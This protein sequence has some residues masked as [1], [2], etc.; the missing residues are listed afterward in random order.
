M[1]RRA[2]RDAPLTLIHAIGGQGDRKRVPAGDR[3]T[4]SGADEV[5]G[6]RGAPSRDASGPSRGDGDRARLGDRRARGATR[7]RHARRRRRPGPPQDDQVDPR[8]PPGRPLRRGTRGGHPGDPGDGTA[9]WP[10]SPGSTAR[11]RRWPPSSSRQQRRTASARHWR[12]CM[13]GGCPPEWRHRAGRVRVGRRTSSRR[14]TVT[15]STRQSSSHEGSERSRRAVWRS[16]PRRR[17][18]EDR[19]GFA[20]ARRGEPRVEGLHPVLPRIGQPRPPGRAACAR[21]DR[22]ADALNA[23]SGRSTACVTPRGPA[24]TPSR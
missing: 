4:V 22:R 1:G 5:D 20:A 11:R 13:R 23:R 21:A 6:R 12:S 24:P 19:R 9:E 15:C 3:R 14:S 18:P 10:S 8:I 7:P 16:A 17:A 2:L